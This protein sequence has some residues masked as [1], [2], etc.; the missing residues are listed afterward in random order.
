MSLLKNSILSLTI[1]LCFNKFSLASDRQFT[2]TYQSKT[3]GKNQRELEVWNTYAS[4]RADF[5]NC[6]DHR[7]EFEVGLTNRLQTSFYMNYSSERSFLPHVDSLGGRFITNSRF[8]VSNEWKYKLTDAVANAFG[9]ALYGELGLWND[10]IELETK[11]ILDKKAG[12]WITAFNIVGEWEL[13]HE[14]SDQENKVKIGTDDAKLELDLGLAYQI[15]PN[16]TFG[17]EARQN[18]VFEYKQNGAMKLE[19]SAFFVGP[20]FSYLSDDWWAAFTLMPQIISFKSSN[21]DLSE[22]ERLNARLVF[23]F[24]L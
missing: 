22:Y 2:F 6:F 16:L 10:E 13:K 11:L 23:A 8:G 5:Y 19:H 14:Y 9:S 17:F 3:L 1:I 20:C 12:K 24:H 4:G 18:N 21:L 15:K 7:S